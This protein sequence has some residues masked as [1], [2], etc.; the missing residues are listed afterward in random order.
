M[1]YK[2]R[3]CMQT[4][5]VILVRVYPFTTPTSLATTYVTTSVSH[6]GYIGFSPSFSLSH[7][8][9]GSQQGS[10]SETATCAHSPHRDHRREGGYSDKQASSHHT[11]QWPP[12]Y[13]S[14]NSPTQLHL[15]LIPRAPWNWSQ[16]ALPLTSSRCSFQ[17]PPQTL[18]A[19][20]WVDLGRRPSVEG[21]TSH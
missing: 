3:K 19:H 11:T 15:H 16:P 7:Q 9:G 8:L 2:S 12:T 20:M 21:L 6:H 18:P 1:Q 10:P 17:L 14:A 13:T 4:R 5:I